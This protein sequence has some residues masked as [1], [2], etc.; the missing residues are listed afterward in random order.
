MADERNEHCVYLR[1]LMLGMVYD[2][3]IQNAGSN[4]QEW[5]LHTVRDWSEGFNEV[6]SIHDGRSRPRRTI[7]NPIGGHLAVRAKGALRS[8]AHRY[9]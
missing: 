7:C 8:D 5:K 2:M 4:H 1:D 6:W 9:F 3:I